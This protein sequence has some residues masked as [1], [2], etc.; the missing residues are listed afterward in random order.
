MTIN[1]SDDDIKHGLSV[2]VIKQGEDFVYSKRNVTEDSEGRRVY[3]H[4]GKPDCIIGQFLAGKG[5]PVERLKR[6]DTT[7]LLGR[8]AFD[9]LDDLREEGVITISWKGMNALR[10]AQS[11][12]DRGRT[13]GDA[14]TLALMEF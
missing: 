12:Q 8:S 6:G 3:V 14:A 13:W 2:L 4:Q 9:L 11:M 5:V 7:T 1:I 10:V